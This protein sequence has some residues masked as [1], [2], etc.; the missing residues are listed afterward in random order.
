MSFLPPAP[1]SADVEFSEP[2]VVPQ[3]NQYLKGVP[4][5]L[6]ANPQANDRKTHGDD[7]ARSAD[8]HFQTGKKFY[9]SQDIPSARR[10]FDAAVD[11]MLEACETNP[12][13]R[14]V[15][16]H[17]LDGLVDSI[18][19]YDLTGRG[20]SA[21]VEEGRFEKAPF[22]DI[23]EMTFPVDPKLKTRVRG[24]VSATVSQLPLSVND[25][26]L[27]YINY[28]N[29][30]GRKTL[31]AAMERSGRYRPMIQ[32][33]LDEEGIPQELIHLAQAESGFIPRALSR[34]AAGGMWQF[35]AWRG[36]E[37]GLARTP[38]IDERM[39]PEKATR[40]AARH[41]RDLYQEFGDWYLAL[42]AYNCGPGSV[43]KAVE[44]TGYADFWELRGR[45]ALPAETTNYVPIILALTIM[46]KNAAEY[47]IQDIQLDSPLESDTVDLSAPV[48]LALVSDI[49]ETPI[50]ELAALNPA[51]LKN[52]APS[53][54]ALHVPKGD[55]TRFLA[56]IQLVPA[57]SRGSWRMHRV[58]PGDTLASIGKRYGATPASI[59]AANDLNSSA[60]IEGDRLLIPAVLRSGGPASKPVLRAAH[61]VPVR[62]AS[63]STRKTRTATARPA[64]KPA[65]KSSSSLVRTAVR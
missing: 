57:E 31:I 21:A 61:K 64:G 11:L 3:P 28:F 51:I 65:P 20:A 47:G 52:T 45:G 27:S 35:L 14:P 38:Y 36:Q 60:T 6:I 54:Y 48:S 44:R 55:A 4:A 8:R 30:R 58:I 56:A 39:D 32:R 62:R 2:P 34:K 49:T 53:G 26:V 5:F 43:E 15:Y 18:H 25:A 19:R 41:L 16:Q 59:I 7:L 22:E 50:S 37:Y 1:H 40:A 63:H 24:Q 23:L 46:E 29:T 10:E 9:Q 17:L 13:D 42:A 33:V 12:A